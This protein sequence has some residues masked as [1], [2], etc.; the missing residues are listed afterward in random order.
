MKAF[1]TSTSSYCTHH[2]A[3]CTSAPVHI[4]MDT[5]LAAVSIVV[6]II[7]LST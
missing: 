3:A 1:A 4:I 7:M 2:A 6:L 5:V